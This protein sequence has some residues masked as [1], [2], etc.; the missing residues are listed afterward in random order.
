M[1][2][3][4]ATE[5]R[6]FI[7]ER[8][9]YRGTRTQA[10][11]AVAVGLSFA[12]QHVGSYYQLERGVAIDLYEVLVIHASIGILVPFAIWIAATV[13]IVVVARFLIG[14]LRTGDVFRLSGWGL[15]PLLA[16]GL[17]QTG[18]RLYALRDADQPDLG[19]FSHL[20]YEWDQYRLYLESANDDPAFVAA[21]VLAIPFVLATGYVWTVV[22][23]ELGGVDGV[24]VDAVT[25]A[26]VAGIPTLL[27]LGWILAPFVL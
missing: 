10:I 19:T 8:T 24:D 5:P 7:R 17:I 23:Q 14:G 16:S 15:S 13:L 2:A 12:L 6:A 20:S 3:N 1:I 25:A 18:G 26:I 4:L 22:A 11:I 21:T 9:K 27:C